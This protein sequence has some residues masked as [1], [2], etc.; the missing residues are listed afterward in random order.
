MELELETNVNSFVLNV[1]KE[2]F[3]K[4]ELETLQKL[5]HKFKNLEGGGKSVS[6]EERVLNIV[7]TMVGGMYRGFSGSQPRTPQHGT[8]PGTPR[9]NPYGEEYY[10][11]HPQGHPP[12]HPHEE[13]YREY[14]A[15][16]AATAAPVPT[17]GYQQQPITQFFQ[18]SSTIPQPPPF[19]PITTMIPQPSVAPPQIEINKL[20]KIVENLSKVIPSN[21][22]IRNAFD[23]IK[24]HYGK[25]LTFQLILKITLPS[26]NIIQHFNIFT[27]FI[28]LMDFLQNN[29]PGYDALVL[30]FLDS[31]GDFFKGVTLTG[32]VA[33][34]VTFIAMLVL[35]LRYLT[36]KV[37]RTVERPVR[38][39]MNIGTATVRGNVEVV[40]QRV[41][42]AMASQIGSLIVNGTM[43]GINILASRSQM[44]GTSCVSTIGSGAT[45]ALSSTSEKLKQALIK[46]ADKNKIIENLMPKQ[47]EEEFLEYQIKKYRSQ[48]PVKYR[49]LNSTVLTGLSI[50][51]GRRGAVLGPLKKAK[52]IENEPAI[53]PNQPNKGGY[54]KIRKTIRKYKVRQTKKSKK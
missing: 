18:S 2:I 29:L 16:Q 54:R 25:L 28:V 44:V 30:N 31:Q 34:K 51:P 32:S 3:S 19:N 40:D 15:S 12:E 39:I 48:T 6:K 37:K 21:E 4:E 45:L 11:D 36:L 33:V 23:F 7:N 38:E 24:K 13:E 50:Q 27:Y 26:K 35:F 5:G 47:L 42:Q 53:P 46:T 1:I 20:K 41:R 52:V 17:A 8:P 10:P 43:E 49:P 14:V 9:F 22:Q